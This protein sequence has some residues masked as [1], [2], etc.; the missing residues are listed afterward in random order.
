MSCDR[1]PPGG[2]CAAIGGCPGETEASQAGTCN[3]PCGDDG[4]CPVG[5]SC[6]R[7]GGE[8][9]C[10]LTQCDAADDC[11]APYP[12]IDGFCRRPRCEGAADCP[13]PLRCD[14]SYCVEP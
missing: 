1:G 4:D 6:R 13:A 5:L 2:V 12:C 7:F 14:R 11:E 10:F 3:L 9:L 8:S